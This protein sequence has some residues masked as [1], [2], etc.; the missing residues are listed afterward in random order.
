M[1]NMMD[2][3]YKNCNEPVCTINK[4]TLKIIQSDSET[5]L[6]LLHV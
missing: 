5:A 4:L 6:T 2:E 3:G 1:K